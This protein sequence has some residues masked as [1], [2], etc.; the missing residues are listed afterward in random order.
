VVSEF[1]ADLRRY[2]LREVTGDFYGGLWPSE[3]FKAHGITYRRS[4]RSK[5]DIYKE[6]LP[7]LN[8]GR[9]ELLDNPRLVAQLVGLERRVGRGGRDSIDHGPGSSDDV[10]NAA[11]GALLASS[12]VS[13]TLDRWRALGGGDTRPVRENMFASERDRP[14]AFQKAGVFPRV[15]GHG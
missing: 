11:A 3:R 7:R 12:G 14:N 9:I 6:L 5:S 15:R 13:S 4:E 10:I 8:A 2:G 1:A